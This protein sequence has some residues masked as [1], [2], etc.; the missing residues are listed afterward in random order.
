VTT[1]APCT[2]HSCC[3]RETAR[4]RLCRNCRGQRLVRRLAILLRAI[5]ARSDVVSGFVEARDCSHEVPGKPPLPTVARS[6]P[7]DTVYADVLRCLTFKASTP[8]RAFVVT[9]P[10]KSN[11]NYVV[12]A[13]RH[14]ARNAARLQPASRWL[15][16]LFP[17][18]VTAV[19]YTSVLVIEANQRPKRTSANSHLQPLFLKM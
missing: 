3:L 7:A 15:P 12:S 17:P 19:V 16:R 10:K 5:S 11:Y 18:D 6:H 13:M 9:N 2:F 8:R 4:E 14:W 1:A